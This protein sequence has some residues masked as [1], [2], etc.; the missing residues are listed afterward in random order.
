M[1]THRLRY[2]EARVEDLAE[3][4]RIMSRLINYQPDGGGS[5]SP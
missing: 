2:L 1:T 5:G 4:N 3:E